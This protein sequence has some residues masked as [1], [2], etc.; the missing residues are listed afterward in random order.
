MLLII[1]VA[2]SN[3]RLLLFRL[4]NSNLNIGTYLF[5]Y[6]FI[7]GKRQRINGDLFCFLRR[8]SNR[9]L[10]PPP[11]GRHLPP[12]KWGNTKIRRRDGKREGK[13][14]VKVL[15]SLMLNKASQGTTQPPLRSTQSRSDNAD[16]RTLN[17]PPPPTT[18]RSR[19][20]FSVCLATSSG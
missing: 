15:S 3:L 7:F 12:P 10:T 14:R 9:A 19:F 2:N 4:E 16:Q 8:A 5:I 18:D 17:R 13:K 20:V 6:L 11:I 1:V